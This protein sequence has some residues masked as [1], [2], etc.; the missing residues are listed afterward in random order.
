MTARSAKPVMKAL[1]IIGLVA[2]GLVQSF[3]TQIDYV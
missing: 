1:L 3:A 2:A